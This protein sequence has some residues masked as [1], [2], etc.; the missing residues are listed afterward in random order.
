MGEFSQTLISEDM[1]R[2]ESLIQSKLALLRHCRENMEAT[3]RDQ[4]E[5]ERNEKLY[6]EA[7]QWLRDLYEQTQE[8]YHG[9]I[10]QLV[11]YCLREV[12][13]EDAY[14]FRIIFEQKR[15][16]VEASLFFE[17]DGELFDPLQA[18]G[19]GVLSVACFALRLSVIYLTKRTVRPVMILDEPFG[20]LS[21]EY[22]DRMASLITE[23]SNKF[24][25]QFIIITHANEFELGKVYKFDKNHKVT[26]LE[27]N[28]DMDV[29]F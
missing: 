22:R 11:S 9:Q 29:G 12:F 27:Q 13:G 1:S 8:R 7:T 3:V 16:Q 20:Q 25:F 2:T 10:M 26:L 18:A 15:N 5:A 24:G 28:E 6:S 14:K 4:T 19:G 21:V 23:L 17:R